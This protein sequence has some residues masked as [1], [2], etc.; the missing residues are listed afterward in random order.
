MFDLEPKGRRIVRAELSESALPFVNVGQPVQIALESDP[1]RTYPGKVVRRAA[2]FGARKLES[3]DPTE[4]SDDF[5]E[6]IFGGDDAGGAALF[7]HH[8]SHLGVALTH[9]TEHRV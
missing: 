2:M 8:D 1:S 9:A 3:D 6:Q 5:G 7:I 4:R